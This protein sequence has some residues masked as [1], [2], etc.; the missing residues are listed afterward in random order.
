MN[1]FSKIIL[2]LVL[3]FTSILIVEHT[4]AQNSMEFFT[5]QITVNGSGCPKNTLENIAFGNEFSTI[6]NSFQVLAKPRQIIHSQCNLSIPVNIPAG[7]TIHD[8]TMVSTGFADIPRGGYGAIHTKIMSET[9]TIGF[10]SKIFNPEY[11]STYE[12]TTKATT[13]RLGSCS[14][15][16]TTM[17]KVYTNLTAGSIN[18]KNPTIVNLSTQDI[19]TQNSLRFIFKANP[20]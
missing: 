18:A 20:Y 12:L 4:N 15:S 5:D 8:I 9:S 19:G 10:A 7:Y 2:T 16:K 1:R 14:S 6:F 17:I 3:S 13:P 11:S